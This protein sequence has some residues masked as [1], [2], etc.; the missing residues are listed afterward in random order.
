M[1]NDGADGYARDEKICDFLMK[2]LS[3]AIKDSDKTDAIIQEAYVNSDS[4][5]KGIVLPNA[6]AQMALIS[7]AYRNASLDCG[8]RTGGNTPRR[9][10]SLLA[11]SC[12]DSSNKECEAFE[13]YVLAQRRAIPLKRVHSAIRS[14]RL[15]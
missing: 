5:T 2:T 12:Y 1:W 11:R 15:A 14:S 6:N 8:V 4:R 10:V 9:T 13:L 7:T 3:Q